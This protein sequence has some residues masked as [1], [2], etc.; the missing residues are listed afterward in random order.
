MHHVNYNALLQRINDLR[1]YA[2][3][4][5]ERLEK[6]IGQVNK[7]EVDTKSEFTNVSIKLNAFETQLR[8]IESDLRSVERE[9][10]TRISN[11]A[12]QL[13]NTQTTL[14][15]KLEQQKNDLLF[16]IDKVNQSMQYL[17]QTKLNVSLNNADKNTFKNFIN[18][19]PGIN[20]DTVDGFH[21]SKTPQA[22][23][24]PVANDRGNINDWVKLGVFSG[25][26]SI[27][28]LT[29]GKRYLVAVYGITADKTTGG[30]YLEPVRIRD[31]QGN[32]LVETQGLWIN[33]HDGNAPQSAVFVIVAPP[34]GVIYG[35]TD[36]GPALNMWAVELPG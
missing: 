15:A 22:N 13:V 33:W 36:N 4:L 29:P 24:I 30:A 8:Q 3:A 11:L 31:S 1:E 14:E 16:E 32:V 20:A 18:S 6:L 23:T 2:D 35:Y 26:S 7:F 12:N 17:E 27:S 10:K 28:G 5:K 25:T 9:L 19:I 34:D 21:A